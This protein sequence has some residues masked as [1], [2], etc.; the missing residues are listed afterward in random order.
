LAD[1]VEE[2]VERWAPVVVVDILAA[3]AVSIR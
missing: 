1:L 3:V 2:E